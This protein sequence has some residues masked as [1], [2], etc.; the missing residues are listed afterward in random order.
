MIHDLK[1]NSEM[2]PVAGMLFA[3][4]EGNYQRLTSI[5]A[6]MTQE[7][8]DYKGPNEEYNSTAQLLKHLAYVDLNWV[9]RIKGEAVS[10]ELEEKYGPMLDE[11]RQLPQVKGIALDV[12]IRNYDDVITRMKSLCY[13]L[14]DKGLNQRV[15]YEN[16]NEATIKWGIWHIADHSRYHQAHINQL[17]KWF[18]ESNS[19]K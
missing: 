2:G 15:E 13:E 18:K 11:N 1:G 5:I 19:V 7:E 17:R 4:V 14:T 8:L 16:G 6:G 12:L 9:F 10:L 3:M